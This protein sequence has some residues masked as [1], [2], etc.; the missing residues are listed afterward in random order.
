MTEHRSTRKGLPRLAEAPL[1]LIALLAAAPLLAL[2]ALGTLVTSGLPI[3]FRQKRVGR[4]GRPFTLWKLRTM[5]ARSEGLPLTVG[6]DPRVTA[7]GGL[8]R[9]T[10]VDELPQLWNVLR[11]D[12]ALVGPRPDSG[13][14]SSPSGPGSRIRSA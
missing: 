14:R 13:K 4:G 7:F 2:A 8:L 10:K 11:G 5:R 12:M 9:R 1:A 3:V 6:K